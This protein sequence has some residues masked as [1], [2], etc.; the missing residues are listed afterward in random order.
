MEVF[1]AEE[2]LQRSGRRELWSVVLL[3]NP[4]AYSDPVHRTD[5]DHLVR[6][7]SPVLPLVRAPYPSKLPVS[8][9]GL[10]SAV[11]PG[12]TSTLEYLISDTTQTS[13]SYELKLAAGTEFEFLVKD[14][15]GVQ[16]FT[17]ELVVQGNP[18]YTC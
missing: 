18:V 6:R 7:L 13:F 12:D 11:T 17:G 10:R 1:D 3:D 9:V 4:Y 8:H 16:A 2:V 15:T 14:S 5:L